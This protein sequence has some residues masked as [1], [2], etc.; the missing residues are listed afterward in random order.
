MFVASMLFS[1][2]VIGLCG[3]VG[4]SQTDSW[5]KYVPEFDRYDEELYTNAIP[6]AAAEA[7]LREN[8]P[9]FTCPDKDIEYYGVRPHGNTR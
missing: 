6:N 7:F 3:G 9:S 4:V 8:A 2:V 1:A 5:A